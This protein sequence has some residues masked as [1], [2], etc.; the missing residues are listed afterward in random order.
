MEARVQQISEIESKKLA[1]ERRIEA[2]D[3]CL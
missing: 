2:R 3:Y 1:A